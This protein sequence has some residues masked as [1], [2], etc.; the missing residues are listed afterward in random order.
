MEILQSS[1]TKPCYEISKD[2]E[3]GTCHPHKMFLHLQE[4]PRNLFKPWFTMTLLKIVVFI[5]RIINDV[6]T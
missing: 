5:F 2:N 3:F 1:K 6:N 4:T